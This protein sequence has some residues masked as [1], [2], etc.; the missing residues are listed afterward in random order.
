MR[1]LWI[2]NMVL[3]KLAEKLEIPTGAS[4]TWMFDVAER[5]DHDPDTEL[6]VACVYGNEF[7]KISVERSVYYCLPGTG[8]DMM[9][10]NKKYVNFWKQIVDDFQPDIV[11]V[12][13]TEY[14]HA[15]SF[16]R[17][18]PNNKTVISLQG[19]MTKIRQ[20]DYAGLS[21]PQILISRTAREWLHF[22]GMLEYHIYHCKNSKTEQE[23]IRTVKYCMV[24]DDWHKS[25]AYEINP[26]LTFFRIHY[27]LRKEFYLS[28]KWDIN[29]IDRY[30][31]TTNP[32]GTALKGLHQ[33]FKAVAIVKERYPEVKVKIPGMKS[34]KNGLVANSGYALFLKR[35]IKRLNLEDNIEF[36]GFQS[37]DQMVSNMLS[38]HIQVVPSAIEGPSLIL[39]EGMHLGVPTIASFRGG[40]ADF[41]DDKVN[42][43]L[44]DFGEYQ[45]LALRILEIFDSDELALRFS[46]KAIE[47]AEIN[48]DP[49]RNYKSYLDMY[50][51]IIKS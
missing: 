27:N 41:V 46:K 11:N 21:L 47:K 18:F 42:G 7:R 23:M 43:F 30:T 24:V 6:A 49:E 10:Y 8:R 39:H 17:S 19:V 45:Y 36:L 1:I 20:Y 29:K 37:S 35:L 9:F 33:L 3:P 28:P 13:G 4:G 44:Y 48:H 14:C 51:E 32:G 22:N 26:K 15:L 50:K 40:M 2:V 31:I 16:I 34:N 25:V 5:L 38:A 12:H